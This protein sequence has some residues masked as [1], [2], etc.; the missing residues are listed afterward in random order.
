MDCGDWQ[1]SI[2]LWFDWNSMDCGDWQVRLFRLN[3]IMVRLKFFIPILSNYIITQSQFH[4]GS[5]EIK[6][7]PVVGL[8]PKWSLNSIM[9]RLKSDVIKE[10]ISKHWKPSQFHYGSIEM[11]ITKL[12]RHF[13][14]SRSQ[15]HYGS[16]EIVLFDYVEDLLDSVSIP[17][18]FDWNPKWRF[19]SRI[20]Q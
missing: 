4:Y 8:R 20:S 18:W 1:V 16:I 12:S 10:A 2:P 9:V 13:N 15:F 5:I 3:S 11:E 6:I 19:P 7:T 14:I 17:L